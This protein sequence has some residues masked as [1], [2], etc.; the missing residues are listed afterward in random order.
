MRRDGLIVLRVA[1]RAYVTGRDLIS[2]LETKGRTN[3]EAIK[4]GRLS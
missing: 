1:G 2:Y 4:S 3:D